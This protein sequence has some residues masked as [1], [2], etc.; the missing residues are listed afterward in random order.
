MK[1]QIDEEPS[2]KICPKV[3]EVSR[4][5]TQNLWSF[6]RAPIHIQLR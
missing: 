1:E 5:D 3:I 4:N 6:K 2:W